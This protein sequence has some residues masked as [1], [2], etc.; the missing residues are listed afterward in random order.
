M[1]FA[2]KRPITIDH[3]KCGSSDSSGYV[4]Y[5]AGDAFL[6]TMASGGGV[7]NASGYDIGFFADAA[8][9][10]KLA[11]ETV[12]WSATTGAG[13]WHIKLPTLSH[14]ADTV[15]Y[16]AYGDA[17][18]TTDQSVGKWDSSLGLASMRH[19]GSPTTLSVGDSI[20]SAD[21]GT[22]YGLT[23]TTG[24]L[25]GAAN[26]N[27]SSYLH[28]SDSGLPSGNS[29]RTI[30]LWFSDAVSDSRTLVMAGYGT[31]SQD[32]AN[33]LA[34]GNS[35]I[36]AFGWGDD[37]IVGQGFSV[38]T[39]YHLVGTFDG[40]A[41]MLYFNGQLLATSSRSWNTQLG[42]GYEIG[43]N[44]G[45]TSDYYNGLVDEVRIAN[46]ARSAGWIT[47]EYNNQSSPSTFY[48]VGAEQ[49]NSTLASALFWIGD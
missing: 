3:T 48:S 10:T 36:V 47:A 25:G 39:W 2:H 35:S 7:Q 28:A 6:A 17:S 11:W 20:A 24:M 32:E 23:A 46:V 43:R 9:T 27:G 40:N 49:A 4:F 18:I 31:G 21:N 38:N 26:C 15:I 13:E 16:V 37:F 1:S 19:F 41:A 5:Y 45:F 42:G 12:W 14:T 44:F 33:G 30:S 8:L 29:P 34:V 22:N